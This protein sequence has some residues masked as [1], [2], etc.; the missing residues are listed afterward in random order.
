MS[1]REEC[2]APV[3]FGSSQAPVHR[4]QP[5]RRRVGPVLVRDG[6]AGALAAGT[7]LGQARAVAEPAVATGWEGLSSA[8]GGNLLLPDNPQFGTAK[9]VFNTNYNAS[10]PA[11]IVTPTS[12]ADVQKAMA[13]A[14]SNKL[15][16]RRPSAINPQQQQQQ[17]QQGG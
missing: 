7:I 4:R 6:A 5:R 2:C 9:Q 1:D 8:I 14:A 10:A 17:Q 13:F 3:R 11:A 12:V 16:K 15:Q